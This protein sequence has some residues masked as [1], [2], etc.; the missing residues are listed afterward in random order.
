MFFAVLFRAAPPYPTHMFFTLF[1]S[2]F[3]DGKKHTVSHVGTGRDPVTPRRATRPSV[4]LFFICE[5]FV[6]A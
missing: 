3:F 5:G 4:V 1:F 6:F 2:I